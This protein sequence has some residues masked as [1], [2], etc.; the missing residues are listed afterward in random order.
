MLQQQL[1]GLGERD[2]TPHV[3]KAGDRVRYE[4]R[5]NKAKGFKYALIWDGASPKG[6]TPLEQA[7]YLN[8]CTV[9]TLKLRHAK[10]FEPAIGLTGIAKKA[11]CGKKKVGK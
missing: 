3:P 2:G 4:E 6:E 5:G 7:R 9:K 10:F 8:K 1:A 11:R